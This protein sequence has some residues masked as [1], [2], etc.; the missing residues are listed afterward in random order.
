MVEFYGHLINH[1]KEKSGLSYL[2]TTII[3]VKQNVLK[4]YYKLFV[5]TSYKNTL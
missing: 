3:R 2:N 5:I 1:N 4:I